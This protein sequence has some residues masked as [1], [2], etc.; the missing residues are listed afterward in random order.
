MNFLGKRK[1]DGPLHLSENNVYNNIIQKLH[2]LWCHTELETLKNQTCHIGFWVGY[3]TL[4]VPYM[5]FRILFLHLFSTERL[6]FSPYCSQEGFCQSSQ[7]SAPERPQAWYWSSSKP[8]ISKLH[9]CTHLCMYIM[10]LQNHK[11]K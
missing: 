3:L 8:N 2:W 9:M 4:L 10:M 5:I 7:T 11:V 1:E 6:S